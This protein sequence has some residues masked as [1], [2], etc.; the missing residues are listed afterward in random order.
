MYSGI[1]EK[2]Y[3]EYIAQISRTCGWLMYQKAG[4]L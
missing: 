3:E 1:N 2:K 4:H